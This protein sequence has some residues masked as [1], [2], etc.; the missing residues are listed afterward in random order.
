MNH[1]WAVAIV[2]SVVSLSAGAA[3]VLRGPVG[4]ALAQWI[5]SW[6]TPEHKAL[7]AQVAVAYAPKRKGAD[8]AELGELRAEVDDLHR[9][10]G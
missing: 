1:D 8:S 2:F 5:A 3:I 6:S 9:Q 4:K 7:E 10:L